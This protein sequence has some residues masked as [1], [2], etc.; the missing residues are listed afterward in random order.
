MA[1]GVQFARDLVN[2][3]FFALGLKHERSVR[4]DND[5]LLALNLIDKRLDRVSELVLENRGLDHKLVF[6]ALLLFVEEAF[7]LFLSDVQVLGSILL[8]VLDELNVV[9][10]YLTTVLQVLLLEFLLLVF[11]PLELL[12]INSDQLDAVLAQAFVRQ[13]FL[14]KDHWHF[15]RLIHLQKRIVLLDQLVRAERLK[16]KVLK[17]QVV[18]SLRLYL[19][20]LEPQLQLFTTGRFLI[21]GGGH[22]FGRF[23]DRALFIDILGD[24][25]HSLESVLP[26][27]RCLV[28]NGQVALLIVCLVVGC[29]RLHLVVV[30]NAA[31]GA[32]RAVRVLA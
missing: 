5:V 13:N 29:Q 6:R 2:A 32:H 31:F 11:L 10:H 17:A 22:Y 14:R 20:V 8:L 24:F 4:L 3:S 7:E 12:L 30:G 28:F 27:G 25:F 18:T 19:S 9:F 1:G 21:I 15:L 26:C 16:P 23:F